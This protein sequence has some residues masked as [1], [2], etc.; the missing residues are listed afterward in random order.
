MQTIPRV[1]LLVSVLLPTAILSSELR[2]WQLDDLPRLPSVEGQYRLNIRVLV[3]GRP[4]A[5]V[6]DREW[7]QLFRN[8]GY[9]VAIATN[10]GSRQPGIQA[11][12]IGRRSVLEVTGLVDRRGILRV[13]DREFR[14]GKSQHLKS[15]LDELAHHGPDGPI[16]MRPTWG[17][18]VPQFTEVLKFMA[19]SVEDEITLS[20]PAETVQ[21][22]RLPPAFRVTWSNDVQNTARSKRTDPGSIDLRRVSLGTGLAMAM[23]QFGLGYRVMKHADS[24]YWLEIDSGDESSNLWPVGWKNRQPLTTVL[25]QL[26]EPVTVD[27]VDEKITE[28]VDTIADRVG[29]PCFCSFRCL[30]ESG[31]QYQ[32]ITYSGTFGRR[33]PFRLLRSISGQH[34]IGIE[35]RTDEAGRVFLWCTTADNQKAWK[36]RFAQVVPGRSEKAN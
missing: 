23:A 19:G 31:I 4:A 1:P 18:S 13:G 21:A 16:R 29:V 15:F 30:A 12:K 11:R 33:S 32:Q 8:A 9:Q 10:D 7:S 22:L 25:P 17:L 35:A 3:S 24:G 28:I 5:R 34:R 6:K 14:L 27:L 20:S 36:K 26:Y 2:A